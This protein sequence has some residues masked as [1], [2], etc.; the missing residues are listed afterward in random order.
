M[1]GA[2]INPEICETLLAGAQK[3][4]DDFKDT[5]GSSAVNIGMNLGYVKRSFE[6][7]AEN[8][9]AYMHEGVALLEAR[10]EKERQNILK[11]E[12]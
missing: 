8:A 2:A 10:E 3:L 5:N 9:K 11:A 7:Q 1:L 4:N 6:N 12:Q